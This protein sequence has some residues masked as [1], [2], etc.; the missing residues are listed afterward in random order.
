MKSVLLG[1]CPLK[2]CSSLDHLSA[3]APKTLPCEHSL[4]PATQR[5]I[6]YFDDHVR[7][8]DNFGDGTILKRH[9]QLPLENHRL[10]RSL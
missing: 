1:W 5:R 9:L 7:G 8:V 10:H 3:A 6:L 2:T 4:L